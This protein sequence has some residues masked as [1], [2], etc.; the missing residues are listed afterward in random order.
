MLYGS[1]SRV[2]ARLLLDLQARIAALERELDDFDDAD[3]ISDQQLKLRCWEEDIEAAR[4][5][6]G[7]QRTRRDVLGELRKHVTEYGGYHIFLHSY[8]IG[9]EEKDRFINTSEQTTSSSK[10]GN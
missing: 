8:S 7:Q 10:R 3:D 2:H 4:E 1:F 9:S 5:A 6:G